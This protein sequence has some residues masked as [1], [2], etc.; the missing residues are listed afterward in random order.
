MINVHTLIRN[1]SMG[2]FSIAGLLCNMFLCFPL[3]LFTLKFSSLLQRDDFLPT[4]VILHVTHCRKLGEETF[5]TQRCTSVIGHRLMSFGPIQDIIEVHLIQLLTLQA[6]VLV[7][8]EQHHQLSPV[9]WS[10]FTTHIF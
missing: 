4:H 9:I 7:E 1:L 8:P 10:T 2:A 3:I 6:V 5:T